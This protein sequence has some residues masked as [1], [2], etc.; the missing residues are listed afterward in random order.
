MQFGRYG[1]PSTS[2]PLVR[3]ISGRTL[4]RRIHPSHCLAPPQLLHKL[5]V[6]ST[7]LLAMCFSTPTDMINFR[8]EMLA[9]LP[10]VKRKWRGSTRTANGCRTLTPAFLVRQRTPN[11]AVRSKE[12]DVS[13]HAVF[14][15]ETV[16]FGVE[17]TLAV[18]GS[19]ELQGLGDA[20]FEGAI[21]GG[22]IMS[23]PVVSVSSGNG[24]DRCLMEIS[25]PVRP[26]V[27]AS[28][29]G[30]RRSRTWCRSDS[31][32]ALPRLRHSWHLRGH[33]QHPVRRGE[34]SDLGWCS[35]ITRERRMVDLRWCHHSKFS[36]NRGNQTA[37][38]RVY[39]ARLCKGSW[40][41]VQE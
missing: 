30:T 31:P 39:R 7:S 4:S 28:W 23:N 3:V 5:R 8:D 18:E 34:W 16:I 12:L 13:S 10:R 19:E 6:R 38:S 29:R 17:V 40:F 14:D 11:E 36:F 21:G 41:G 25:P 2:S 1:R 9:P 37:V 26:P 27:S 20:V 15:H 22:P 35:P 24:R 32:R 33:A